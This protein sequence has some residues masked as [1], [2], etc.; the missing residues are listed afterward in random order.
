L[1]GPIITEV[2]LGPGSLLKRMRKRSYPACSI[3]LPISDERDLA[4]N[5]KQCK[6]R[7]RRT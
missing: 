5:P 4:V 3:S 1:G 7:Q 6:P 2:P